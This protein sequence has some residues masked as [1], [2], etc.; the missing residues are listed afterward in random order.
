[1]LFPYFLIF[2]QINLINIYKN[3]FLLF[4]STNLL[5]VCLLQ[6]QH[7]RGMDADKVFSFNDLTSLLYSVYLCFILDLRRDNSK[8]NCAYFQ[9]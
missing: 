3:L 7:K 2:H 6:S 4:S 5:L 1:M 9:L 8:Y